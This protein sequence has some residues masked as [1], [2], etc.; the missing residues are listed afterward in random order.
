MTVCK[1]A[2]SDSKVSVS[3]SSQSVRLAETSLRLFLESLNTV[4]L[5][6]NVA[7][8]ELILVNA[9]LPLGRNAASAFLTPL[10]GGGPLDSLLPSD[11]E[12]NSSHSGDL[13]E[14]PSRIRLFGAPAIF[15]HSSKRLGCSSMLRRATMADFNLMVI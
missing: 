11:I 2:H 3:L 15:R 5:D 12:S 9:E 7:R 1:S 13:V 6:V 4:V 8:D 14:A 10:L